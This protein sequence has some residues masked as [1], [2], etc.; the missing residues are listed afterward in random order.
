LKPSPRAWSLVTLAVATVALGAGSPDCAHAKS[1]S[2][3]KPAS[4]PK[5]PSHA[6][7]SKK[8][9]EAGLGRPYYDKGERL[10]V[11]PYRGGE[12]SYTR[13]T[14]RLPPRV[15]FDF[16]EEASG[17]GILNEVVFDHPTWLGWAMAPHGAK[18][19]QTRLTLMF[20]RPTTVSVTLDAHR[21][22][23]LLM[24]STD[25]QGAATPAPLAV[26]S[27]RVAIPGSARTPQEL[28]P[29]PVSEAYPT[30][31]TQPPE[32]PLPMPELSMAPHPDV[33]TP[34]FV[35]H[36]ATPAPLPSSEPSASSVATPFV[37]PPF[38]TP[39]AQAPEAR[40]TLTPFTP[41]TPDAYR[42]APPTDATSSLGLVLPA[43]TYDETDPALGVATHA[44]LPLAMDGRV[45]FGDVWPGW[46]AQID[47]HVLGLTTFDAF[48]ALHPRQEWGVQ[49]T[50]LRQAFWSG[51]GLQY[52]L[53]YLARYQSSPGASGGSFATTPWRLAHGPSLQAGLR[54]PVIDASGWAVRL[55]GSAVPMLLNGLPSG[56]P[57]LPWM[58]GY[59]FEVG[60][61][62]PL[63]ALRLGGGYR[64][65]A[66]NAEGYAEL[67][68]G[69]YLSLRL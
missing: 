13:G 40:P 60:V 44:D 43:Y 32:S 9:N 30:P 18:N 17:I 25:F 57:A 8:A 31:D 58:W 7:A 3:T 41:Y 6:V 39:Q 61:E 51:V 36:P 21:H 24:P 23:L 14:L 38:R 65:A 27:P 67:Y 54:L 33:H 66:F 28:Y 22:A 52:G 48:H 69:P 49:A 46:N 53:G 37:H 15:Y 19:A 64:R 29:S 16:D 68:Q 55:E 62:A 20:K 47:A 35:F 34:G 45:V 4:H 26:V 2:H 12:P 10:L 50:V 56:V 59:A 42:P 1:T 63:G 5:P 11:L